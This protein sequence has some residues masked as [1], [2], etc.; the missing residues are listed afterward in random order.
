MD[1]NYCLNVTTPIELPSDEY[2][3][4]LTDNVKNEIS[5]TKNNF[6]IPHN[7]DQQ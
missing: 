3:P 6:T 4:T 1:E 7:Y 2:K 5:L